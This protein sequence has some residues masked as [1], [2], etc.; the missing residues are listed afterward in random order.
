MTPRTE[1][2]S[3]GRSLGLA[4]DRAIVVVTLAVV[5]TTAVVLAS[6]QQVVA[7]FTSDQAGNLIAAEPAPAASIP[8]DNALE[9]V[10]EGT[11]Q[12]LA[13]GTR[14]AIGTSLLGQVSLTHP[15]GTSFS[16]QLDLTVTQPNAAP[17]ALANATVIGT[18]RMVGMDM[19]TF[20]QVATPAS[21]GRYEL[22]FNFPMSGEWQIELQVA[23]PTDRATATVNV[24]IWS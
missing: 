20:R 2:A 17:P 8:P 3:A 9:L 23:T 19:G 7:R 15:G 21:T 22:G 12:P 6:G 10:T 13:V 14:F 16:R 18:A 24:Y 11:A 5:V 1:S 4:F